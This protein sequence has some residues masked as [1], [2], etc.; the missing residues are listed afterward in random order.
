VTEYTVDG[1]VKFRDTCTGEW[2]QQDNN[3]QPKHAGL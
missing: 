3:T 2:I 1:A